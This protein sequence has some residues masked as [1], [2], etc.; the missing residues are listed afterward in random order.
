M[1]VP[2][3]YSPTDE[4][5]SAL[6]DVLTDALLNSFERI[7]SNGLLS[8][9]NRRERVGQYPIGKIAPFK[10]L[11]LTQKAGRPITESSG[12]EKSRDIGPNRIIKAALQSLFANYRHAP[13]GNRKSPQNVNNGGGKSIFFRLNVGRAQIDIA[14]IDRHRTYGAEQFG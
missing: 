10:T 5:P 13:S 4:K 9:Y 1:V 6:L 2:R 3:V 8:E 11:W 12:F 7:W 14:G